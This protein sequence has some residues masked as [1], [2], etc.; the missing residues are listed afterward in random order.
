MFI[1]PLSYL[2]KPE[3][4]IFNQE[5]QL[6]LFVTE[7]TQVMTPHTLTPEK[8]QEFFGVFIGSTVQNKEKGLKES[9]QV[10]SYFFYPQLDQIRLNTKITFKNYYP[11][12]N[13]SVEL[14]N[15]FFNMN[16][17]SLPNPILNNFG[18]LIYT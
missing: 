13:D 7:L 11:G 1:I 8:Y 10:D 14:T 2:N 6:S 16:Q 3:T 18:N 15:E 9:R 12:K 17:I 4:Y 5:E